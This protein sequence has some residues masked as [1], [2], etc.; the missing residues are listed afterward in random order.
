MKTMGLWP[1]LKVFWLCSYNLYSMLNE[2]EEK[3]DRRRGGKT[4]L[5]IEQGWIFASKTKAAEDRTKQESIG[6]PKILQSYGI[7][8]NTV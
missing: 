6:F 2:K 5:K 3:I 1:H 7:N 8:Q 4:V